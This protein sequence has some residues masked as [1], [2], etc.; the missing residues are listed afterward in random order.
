MRPLFTAALGWLITA[1]RGPGRDGG[2]LF[3]V[4]QGFEV[5]QTGAV[6][7][8]RVQG[9][10]RVLAPGFLRPL[11]PGTAASAVGNEKTG[12][13]C[14]LNGQTRS[15]DLAFTACGGNFRCLSTGIQAHQYRAGG[16]AVL[17]LADLRTESC[18]CCRGNLIAS[19]LA[20]GA[21]PPAR[22]CGN[23]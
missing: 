2:F 9:R 12:P 23:S 14:P 1:P 16:K 17:P 21:S 19:A 4:P 8:C 6:I 11:T 13:C 10:Q 18:R 3:F 15:L 5:G 7:A 22:G 20:A